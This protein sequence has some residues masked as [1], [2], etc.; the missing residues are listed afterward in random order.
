MERHQRARSKAFPSGWITS[1]HRRHWAVELMVHGL[2]R[3]SKSAH[4]STRV[5]FFFTLS[6]WCNQRG[7]GPGNYKFC[8]VC[9]TFGIK[10]FRDFF[11]RSAMSLIAHLIVINR[12][13]FRNPFASVA[14]ME[15]RREEG[16]EYILSG[17]IFQV[18]VPARE[19]VRGTQTSF[20]QGR[21]Y[22]LIAS[23]GLALA[24][25]NPMQSGF[26][27]PP[28]RKEGT[29][30]PP[31]PALGELAFLEYIHISTTVYAIRT[32]Y[33]GGVRAAWTKKKEHGNRLG[34]VSAPC[35]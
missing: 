20:A 6:R 2:D 10:I 11:V 21:L 4:F 3:H 19:E 33:I 27:A 16:G 30:P 1:G 25:S 5:V 17:E 32:Y 13:W 14:V 18:V 9:W 28:P 12:C 23:F 34:R 26:L 7:S 15:G 35:K 22:I 29:Q 24:L 31:P 8:K